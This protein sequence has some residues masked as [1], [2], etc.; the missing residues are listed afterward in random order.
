VL[1]LLFCRSKERR[2]IRKPKL[3]AF[4]ERLLKKKKLAPE[5]QFPPAECI[6]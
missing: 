3:A 5:A 2:K 4:F 1:I 6:K